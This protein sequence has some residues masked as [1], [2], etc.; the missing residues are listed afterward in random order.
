MS[1]T[2][3]YRPKSLDNFYIQKHF[4]EDAYKWINKPKDMP[5]LLLYGPAGTGKTTAAHC[6][7]NDI[8]KENISMNVLEINASQ[9]R[10]LETVR[11][12]ILRFTK[13]KPLGNIPFKICILDEMDG[14]TI[15]SQLALKRIMEK[16]TNVR[17]ILTCNNI[18]G[19][20]HAVRSR[21]MNYHFGKIEHSSIV[22]VLS[23]IQRIIEDEPN[24]DW[25][26]LVDFNSGDIRAA[27]IEA[28]ASNFDWS[29]KADS[30]SFEV[31]MDLLFKGDPL[32]ALGK[33]HSM[34]YEGHA[35]TEICGFMHQYIL[36]SDFDSNR[37][38]KYLAII[39]EAEWRSVTANPQLLLSWLVAKL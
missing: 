22:K 16:A 23:N 25:Q 11:E 33:L 38:F 26:E 10:K 34:T 32:K 31:I 20:D 7:V 6:L 39:G 29:I 1:W 12:T 35:V 2:E 15:N 9:D 27:I 8:V 30:S 5:N 14:M 24:E 21:C 18:H 36:E 17:F 28:Q 4:L 37:K 13:T 19:I 3:I